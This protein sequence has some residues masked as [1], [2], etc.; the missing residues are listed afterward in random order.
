MNKKTIR[1][2]D[3]R[4]KRVLVRVDLNVPI[5]TETGT[6]TDETRIRAIVPTIKYL[7]D[8]EAR[9]ILCSH[10]G[11]PKGKAIESLRLWPVAERLSHI[12]GKEVKA[13]RDCIGPDVSGVVA[14]MKRG[15]ILLLENLRFQ[16][17]EEDNDD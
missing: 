7:I 11:R 14:A 10:L 9:V 6:I 8:N 1:G 17:E 16:S 3:V 12:M 5:D 13:T 4:D 2:I 15:D